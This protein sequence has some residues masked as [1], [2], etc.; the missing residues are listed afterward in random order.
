MCNNNSS[1]KSHCCIPCG[2]L[3]GSRS[4]LT[5]HF[6]L[7]KHINKIQNPDT[8]I[9]GGFKCPK[10]EKMYKSKQG[11]WY[12]KKFCKATAVQ[13]PV[14]TDL[15]AKLDHLERIIIEMTRNHVI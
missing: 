10:C 11:L 13:V 3:C 5:K 1:T 2:Y 15:L 7:K 12:H 14:E 4:N 9:V 8:V 6:S